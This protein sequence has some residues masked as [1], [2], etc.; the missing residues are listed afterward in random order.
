[1]LEERI[2]HFRTMEL[3]HWLQKYGWKVVGLSTVNR[4][5]TLVTAEGVPVGSVERV[6]NALD[7]PR[8]Y[9]VLVDDDEEVL[10]SMTF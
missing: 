7:V 8:V 6:T 2:F 1:M 5:G 3:I 4:Y 10:E 9:D